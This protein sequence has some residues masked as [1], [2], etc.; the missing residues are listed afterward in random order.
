MKTYG[1]NIRCSVCDSEPWPSDP[2]VRET[3]DLLRIGG[4]W[5]CELHRPPK[6]KQ[7][8]RLVPTSPLEAVTEF[9]RLFSVQGARLKGALRGRDDDNSRVA[10]EAYRELERGLA[11]LKTAVAPPEPP[12]GEAKPARQKPI[13]KGKRSEQQGD[14]L[15][16]KE[17][18]EMQP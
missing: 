7:A 1:A 6:E 4:S 13:S 10:F 9:E 8:P 2:A 16:E 5:F 17:P 12:G 15:G 14:W 3:F 18:A 11:S